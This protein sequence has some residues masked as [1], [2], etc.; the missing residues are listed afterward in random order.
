MIQSFINSFNIFRKSKNRYTIS[1]SL[2]FL[3]VLIVILY[4]YHHK[5]TEELKNLLNNIFQFSGIYSALLITFIVSKIFQIRQEKLERLRE[6][7]VLSH[8]TTDFRRIC[9]IIVEC[10]SFWD[11]SMRQTMD[12]KFKRLSYFHIQIDEDKNRDAIQK[13]IEEFHKTT[14][15]PGASFYLAVKS[16]VKHNNN[17]FQLELYDDYDYNIEYSVDIL[18][19]WVG[20]YSANCFYYY[21]DHKRAAYKNVFNFSAFSKSDQEKIISLSRKINE[22]KYHDVIFGT[23]LFVNIGNDFNSLILPRLFQLTYNNKTGL[24]KTL[25]F[26]I[27]ILIVTMIFGV[28]FPLLLSSISIDNAYVILISNL[29][30]AIL[31]FSILYFVIYFKKIL[32]NEI[33]ISRENI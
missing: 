23:E 4:K 16:F 29:S 13:L 17:P 20:A 26:L 32:E 15:I 11:K 27:K 18:D 31:S 10:D 33:N 14:N 2:F 5:Q 28:F 19:K 24:P 9:E 3:L 6:I 12:N 30:I 25:K 8:K 1:F 7:I 21:L 22:K